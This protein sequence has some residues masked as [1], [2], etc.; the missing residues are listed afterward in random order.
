MMENCSEIFLSEV[1]HIELVKASACSLPVPFNVPEIVTMNS[2]VIGTP[3]MTLDVNDSASGITAQMNAPTL[4]TQGKTQASG[5]LRNHD[6]QIPVQYGYEEVRE[7]KGLLAGVDFYAVLRT[8]AGTEFLLYALPNT[9]SVSVED[10][11][12][13][14]QK[15]TVKVSMQSLSNMIRITRRT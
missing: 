7:A 12:G 11:F 15:Q 6:L 9:S 8:V 10:Q 2:C 1:T 14:E 13:G 3:L 5:Y 4:K